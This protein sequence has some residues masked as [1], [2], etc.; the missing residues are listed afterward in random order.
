MSHVTF[1]ETEEYIPSET[2]TTKM[3]SFVCQQLNLPVVTA[4]MNW[5]VNTFNLRKLDVPTEYKQ[6]IKTFMTNPFQR[7]IA[8][9]LVM[10]HSKC[11]YY[12]KT[13][14]NSTDLSHMTLVMYDKETCIIERFDPS[15]NV[16]A[17]DSHL[18][19]TVLIN[20][21]CNKFQIQIKGVYTP[22]C[23][24]KLL[25][26]GV[27]TLQEQEVQEPLLGINVGFC[28]IYVLWYLQNR[29]EKA[30]QHPAKT[31]YESTKKHT[32]LTEMIK[33]MTRALLQ[34]I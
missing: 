21:F 10:H 14:T 28:S 27:Q 13:T 1:E 7:F 4:K 8:F 26:T 15:N 32:D 3:F 33:N 25:G 30:N 12:G 2:T 22:W 20:V 23:I 6:I 5:Y 31:L 29:M 19:D 16:Y 9:P 18:I 24:N 34:K 17:F 11:I